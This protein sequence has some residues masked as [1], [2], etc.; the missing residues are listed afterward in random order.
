MNVTWTPT[1]L[2][3]LGILGVFTWWLVKYFAMGNTATGYVIA[4]HIS[5][6][7]AVGRYHFLSRR[8]LTTD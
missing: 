5:W 7:V 1:A 4:V 8:F 3:E 6:C 2:I